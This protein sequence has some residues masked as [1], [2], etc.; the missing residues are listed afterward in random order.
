[1]YEKS[2]YIIKVYFII[3]R[4][5]RKSFT[6]SQALN[7]IVLNG[8]SEKPSNCLCPGTRPDTEKHKNGQTDRQTDV[9][10]TYS[11]ISVGISNVQF[12]QN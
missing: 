1:V 2:M 6:S 12:H 8:V 5:S 4:H 11:E 9:H 10:T 7:E 3:G